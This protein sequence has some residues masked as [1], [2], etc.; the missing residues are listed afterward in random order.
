M[1][2]IS[3]IIRVVSEIHGVPETELIAKKSSNGQRKAYMVLLCYFCYEAILNKES[4]CS[5]YKLSKL[6]NCTHIAI[7]RAHAEISVSKNEKKCKF[8]EV[9]AIE[10]A[11]RLN[12]Y[13]E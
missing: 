10:N 11:I 6:I 1:E 7:V 9:L 5:L 2:K 8:Y 12:L 13:T 3:Q 4:E